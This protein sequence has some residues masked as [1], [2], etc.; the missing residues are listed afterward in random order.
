MNLVEPTFDTYVVAKMDDNGF[1]NFELPMEIRTSHPGERF[2]VAV[3]DYSI[4]RV[5]RVHMNAY[6]DE[7]EDEFCMYMHC[8]YF[9]KNNA[10]DNTYDV[11]KRFANFRLQWQ[12]MPPNEPFKDRVEMMQYMLR[13][14]GTLSLYRYEVPADLAE[15]APAGSAIPRHVVHPSQYIFIERTGNVFSLRIDKKGLMEAL[16]GPFAPFIQSRCVLCLTDHLA[17]YFDERKIWIME[18]PIVQSVYTPTLKT[19]SE[20]HLMMED[21]TNSCVN[22]NTRPLLLTY[23][24]D[25]FCRRPIQTMTYHYLKENHNTGNESFFHNLRMWLEN[26]DGEKLH[27]TE[28]GIVK[29]DLS[30]RRACGARKRLKREEN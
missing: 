1:L 19:M 4:P 9:G 24:E 20:V 7:N 17:K 16:A 23:S 12:S 18:K 28:P 5:L 30:W 6:G 13:N 14:V 2:L 25:N 21:C 11:E 22:K 3:R 8:K 29:L 10:G 15:Q 27:L 26:D